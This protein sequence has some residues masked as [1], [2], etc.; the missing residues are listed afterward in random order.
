MECDAQSVPL[1]QIIGADDL[2]ATPHVEYFIEE[3]L[4]RDALSEHL[5]SPEVVKAELAFFHE[6]WLDCNAEYGFALSSDPHGGSYNG[7]AMPEELECAGFT[8]EELAS[9]YVELNFD[10]LSLEQLVVASTTATVTPPYGLVAEVGLTG[11]VNGL[12][13][14][15][16]KTC[17]CTQDPA[18]F[19]CYQQLIA[20]LQAKLAVASIDLQRY[21][22][23]RIKFEISCD[24]V[25]VCYV[26][27]PVER[28]LGSCEWVANKALLN[29]LIE[30]RRAAL[31]LQRDL[32]DLQPLYTGHMY[33]KPRLQLTESWGEVLAL[34]QQQQ[35]RAGKAAW[36]YPC[37]LPQGKLL[38]MLSTT[39]N[40]LL[41]HN[42]LHFT[43]QH[44]ASGL[45]MYA[46]L[47]PRYE[48]M[49]YQCVTPLYLK[50]SAQPLATKP[51]LSDLQRAIMTQGSYWS[52]HVVQS[53]G[54]IELGAV[55]SLVRPVL[56]NQVN[57][58]CW[59][60][61]FPGKEPGAV[62]VP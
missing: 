35:L 27:R 21:A 11:Y 20:A 10:Q 14:L 26:M 3:S 15:K 62:I 2:A 39:E 47:S 6:N 16:A 41:R 44:Y 34:V 43:G 32:K 53:Y 23:L 49:N 33:Y 8:A 58:Q 24:I 22:N 46:P 1:V 29:F 19:A 45:D 40:A 12:N 60:G 50:R 56:I 31:N 59:Y 55:I 57:P 42:H 17:R 4:K 61:V 52:E 51:L 54:M 48:C 9:E 25:N 7:Y 13:Y 36:S 18:Q 5:L 28:D 37:A 38:P 30:A